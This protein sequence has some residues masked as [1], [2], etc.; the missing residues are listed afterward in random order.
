M[1]GSVNVPVPSDL[2][3]N[4]L[5]GI[6]AC[7]VF[8][9][10]KHHPRH[11]LHIQDHGYMI[12]THS[13]WCYISGSRDQSGIG[14]SEEFGKIESYHL[15]V[16]YYPSYFFGFGEDW[17][18]IL[19][20]VDANG[21]SEIKVEFRPKFEPK[22]RSRF[23]PQFRPQFGPEGPRWEVTKCGARLVSERDIEDL[24]NQ[25]KAGPSDCIITPYD[26]DGFDNSEKDSKIKRSSDYSNGEGAGPSGEATS[27]DEP[28]HLNLIEN[29]FGNSDCEEEESQ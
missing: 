22:F 13:L 16:R 6:A 21:F 3:G 29:W 25:T 24:I 10:R 26:E 7:A 28:P 12:G 18:E 23:G 8:A 5:M 27:N 15:L 2:L 9:Y 1:G 19:N 17:E 20:Q 4:K 14:L 11:Q